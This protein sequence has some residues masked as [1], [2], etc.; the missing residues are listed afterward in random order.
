M[1]KNIKDLR[2]D[3]QKGELNRTD[4][5]DSPFVQF[6]QWFDQALNDDSVI[7]PNGMVLST[8]SADQKPSSRVVLLKGLS[9]RGFIFYTNYSSRKG[10]ELL[11]NPH[12]ALN[13]WWRAQQRQVRIE[14]RVEKIT[15][16]KSDDYF[17][18]RPQGSQLSAMVSPQSKPIPNRAYLSER[19]QQLRNELAAQ[20]KIERPQHWGGYE[21]TPDLVEFWQGRSSRLHDR[22]RYELR[23]ATWTIERLAP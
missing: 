13:F 9:D 23:D 17:S 18:S 14:G 12:A 8:V 21:L 7:E 11:T 6:A 2:T 4:L 22:F 1:E 16:Q 20:T 19:L 3:Y 10:S 15:P 5:H